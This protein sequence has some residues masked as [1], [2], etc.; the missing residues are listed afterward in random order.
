MEFS[1]RGVDTEKH[2]VA[3]WQKFATSLFIYKTWQQNT[4]QKEYSYPFN[5]QPS[6][7]GCK[8]IFL[9]DHTLN[10]KNLIATSSR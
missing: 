6:V 9:S 10:E 8:K 2:I 3:H 1:H 4:S 7:G 5:S